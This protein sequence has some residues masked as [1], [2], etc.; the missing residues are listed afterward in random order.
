[1]TSSQLF[2][3]I[4]DEYN[5]TNKIP[6]I[7]ELSNTTNCTEEAIT[8]VL[9]YFVKEGRILEQDGIYSFP[10]KIEKT[11]TPIIKEK[12]VSRET[13]KKPD[14]LYALCRIIMGIVG[15][16]CIANSIRFTYAFNILVMPNFW[17]FLLSFSL[18]V[19]TSFVFTVRQYLKEQGKNHYAILFIILWV[20]GITYSIFTAV[21]GQYNDFTSVS[22]VASTEVL[23]SKNELLKQQKEQ[24]TSNLGMYESQLKQHQSIIDDLSQTPE[25]KVEYPQTW[26]E[27]RNEIDRLT[28]LIIDTQQQIADIDFELIETSVESNDK[29]NVFDWLSPL[30]RIDSDSIQFIISLFPAVFIDLVSPFAI[31]FAFY[32][33]KEE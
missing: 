15:I 33:R 11:E 6:T 14:I 25:K 21:A 4:K 13:K 32:R 17:A 27:S 7:H 5:K 18:I 1:M 12:V 2:K 16:G 20:I 22:T 28:I 23:E 10:I 30:L 26:R 9:D 8:R 31:M 29:Q 3:L 24:L 19:F